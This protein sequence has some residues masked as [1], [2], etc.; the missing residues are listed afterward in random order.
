MQ[1]TAFGCTQN[2]LSSS[3]LDSPG[4]SRKHRLRKD[5][6]Q[7]ETR[8]GEALTQ[9]ER[10]NWNLPGQRGKPSCGA[11][12]LIIN[13]FPWEEKLLIGS[14]LTALKSGARGKQKG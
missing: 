11:E 5:L 7:K 9:K 2:S 1:I 3:I 4:F 13:I 8:P 10:E 6:K 14:L 12:L